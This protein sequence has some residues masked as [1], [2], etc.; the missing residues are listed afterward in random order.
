LDERKK[1]KASTILANFQV[2]PILAQNPEEM[3]SHLRTEVAKYFPTASE[4]IEVQ[5]TGSERPGKPR[6]L[7]LKF[8]S[9]AESEK[10]KWV[11]IGK[12]RDTS[13]AAMDRL[14]QD[15]VKILWDKT[16]TQ[17]RVEQYWKANAPAGMYLDQMLWF[18]NSFDGRP[19]FKP[20]RGHA[21]D[22]RS[23]RYGDQGNN[24]ASQ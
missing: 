23:T 6:L 9:A 1:R 18:E 22:R 5:C 21:G 10:F 7:R 20:T 16:F 2:P 15:G 24:E 17:L 11:A 4:A 14:R 13:D 12:L 19:I 3:S 8:R